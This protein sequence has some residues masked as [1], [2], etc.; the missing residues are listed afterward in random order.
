SCDRARPRGRARGPCDRAT[1]SARAHGGDESGACGPASHRSCRAPRSLLRSRRPSCNAP[2]AMERLFADR[3]DA[4]RKLAE[5]LLAYADDPSV[6]VLGLPRG[7]VPVA[8]EVAARL[9]APLDVFVVRKLGVPGHRELAMGAI[10]SGGV[11]ILHV[12]VIRELG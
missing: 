1:R 5:R 2:G 12:D 4:G 6:I 10:A 7:G 8:Y 9:H 11:R 3:R